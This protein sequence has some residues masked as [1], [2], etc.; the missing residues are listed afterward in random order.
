[1]AAALL[2][3]SAGSAHSP[4]PPATS[5]PFLET[6]AASRGLSGGAP[7]AQTWKSFPDGRGGY[8]QG[9]AVSS[10]PEVWAAAVA[11]LTDGR[12]YVSRDRGASWSAPQGL[13]PLSN[14]YEMVQDGGDRRTIYLL[15]QTRSEEEGDT[16][17]IL[18]RSRDGGLSFSVV[19]TGSGIEKPEI[20]T[21]R[22]GA[23]PLYMISEGQLWVSKDQGS[24]FFPPGTAAG[25]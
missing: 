15:A 13:P 7:S 25:E 22:T 9:F 4:V 2:A 18:A 5:H 16:A 14:V 12:V 20:W 19:Y 6:G 11:G 3:L 8:L 10:R 1:M 24:T 23:G 21:N 17:P